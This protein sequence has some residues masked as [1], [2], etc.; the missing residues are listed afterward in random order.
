[1][2]SKQFR[3]AFRCRNCHEVTVGIDRFRA[4][5]ARRRRKAQEARE[6][7]EFNNA[8]AVPLAGFLKRYEEEK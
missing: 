5:Q 8:T 1:M 6:R 3:G 4:Q 2:P 7:E